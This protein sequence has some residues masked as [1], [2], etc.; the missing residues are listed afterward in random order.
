MR[1]PRTR[2]RSRC[3]AVGSPRRRVHALVRGR[4]RLVGDS[5]LEVGGGAGAPC[6]LAVRG[7]HRDPCQRRGE[8]RPGPLRRVAPTRRRRD[9]LQARPLLLGALDQTIPRRAYGGA[10]AGEL[11]WGRP[12]HSRVLRVLSNPASAGVYVFGRCRTQRLVAADG[13]VRETIWEQPRSEWEVVIQNHHP[14]YIS[15]GS[16]C[17]TRIVW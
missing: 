14:G 17:S 13:S 3:C 15:W 12:T 6:C 5:D 7:S 10:W 4:R 1:Y 2:R 11:R 8:R 16:T 9:Q